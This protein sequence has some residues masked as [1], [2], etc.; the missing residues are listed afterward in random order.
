MGAISDGYRSSVRHVRG[1]LDR[2][3][4]NIGNIESRKD[5]TACA[6]NIAV[7]RAFDSAVLGTVVAGTVPPEPFSTRPT[8]AIAFLSLVLGEN[9]LRTENRSC[10][11]RFIV[12]RPAAEAGTFRA[13]RIPV[14][15]SVENEC[16]TS[17]RRRIVHGQIESS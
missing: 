6:K 7:L 15:R 9:I 10:T 2:V 1:T 14:I 3:V 12:N 13:P 4:G 8:G 5:L 17:S 11:L 16:S